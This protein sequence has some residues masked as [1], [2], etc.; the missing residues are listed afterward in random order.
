MIKVMIKEPMKV[1]SDLSNS[2]KNISVFCFIGTIFSS[3]CWRSM[4]VDKDST[5]FCWRILNPHKIQD[6][7][8]FGKSEM[9]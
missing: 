4:I 5:T 8:I 9:A 2:G 3:L 6:I 1:N 7:Y